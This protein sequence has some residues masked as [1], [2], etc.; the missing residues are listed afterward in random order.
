VSKGRLLAEVAFVGFVLALVVIYFA[1]PERAA[2]LA[3]A[4]DW[5]AALFRLLFAGGI[6]P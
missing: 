2:A 6:A 5:Y 1:A 3:G 4:H